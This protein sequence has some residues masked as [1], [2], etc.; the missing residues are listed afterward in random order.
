[1]PEYSDWKGMTR[2]DYQ[3]GR[4]E[5]YSVVFLRRHPD[6]WYDEARYDSHDRSR[7]RQRLAPRFHLKLRGAFK[8]DT[9]LAEAEIS[10]IIAT[11]VSRI[12]AILAPE[13]GS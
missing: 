7:G 12:E 6:G 9:N 11:Q 5:R 13:T 8:T 1:M 4:M 3:D 2:A 10:R